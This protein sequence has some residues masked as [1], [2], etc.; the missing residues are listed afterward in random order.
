MASSGLQRDVTIIGSDVIQPIDIQSHYQQ[1]IQTHNAVS[2][3]LNS[4]S[5][6]S[7]IDTDG[8]DKVSILLKGDSS[9]SNSVDIYW[10]VDGTSD[11][12]ADYAIIPV[13]T[14][15]VGDAIIDT[16]ARYFRLNVK[17]MDT[18]LAHTMSAYVYLK[19]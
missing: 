19:A 4:A 14:R 3:A 10:S 6:S 8:F 2:I 1:T 15:S 13:G 11:V 9:F 17:N 5:M 12:G 18:A 16:R 7:Y